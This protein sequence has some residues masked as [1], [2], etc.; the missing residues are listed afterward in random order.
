MQ[1][2]GPA[3]VAQREVSAK[4]RSMISV[5]CLDVSALDSRDPDL[6]ARVDA[7]RRERIER[8]AKDEDKRL[9]LGA[10]LLLVEHIGS[11][12]V[13][14]DERGKPFRAGDPPFSLSHSKT[15]ALLVV[16]S[17]GAVGC[18]VEHCRSLD[19]LKIAQRA[20]A[21]EELRQIERAT[22]PFE[23]FFRIWTLR[24]SY[25]KAT[26][27]GIAGDPSSVC[28]EVAEKAM[29]I[30]PVAD[31]WKF[32]EF[33]DVAGYRIAVCGEEPIGDVEIDVMG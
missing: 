27:Q 26:G 23:M 19:Y 7:Q 9:C 21:A 18:D 14:R 28:F 15:M 16:G 11:A 3:E 13:E 32:R 4:G 17:M 22:D 8:F 31:N 5:H 24:E 6:L 33:S 20:F 10:G 25:L 29:L 12:S 1:R 2:A 30:R